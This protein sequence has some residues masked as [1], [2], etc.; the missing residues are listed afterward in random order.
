MGVVAGTG[1]VERKKG[2]C[3][4]V[5]GVGSKGISNTSSEAAGVMETHWF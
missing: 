4:L 1:R 5:R 3:M 2:I